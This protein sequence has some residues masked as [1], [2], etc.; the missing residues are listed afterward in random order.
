MKESKVSYF[1]IEERRPVIVHAFRRSSLRKR[2]AE[3]LYEISPSSSYPSEI[4][5]HVKSTP[6]NVLG[7]L[8]G[9]EPRYRREES[10][11]NLSIVEAYMDGRRMR[12]YKLTDFGKEIVSS[13]KSE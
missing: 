3:Y 12:L 10:L 8:R 6:T 9:M 7:A 11:L 1:S 4:A 5:Y 2:I 13:L